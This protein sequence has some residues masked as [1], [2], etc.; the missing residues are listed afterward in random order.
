MVTRERLPTCFQYLVTLF[1]K[2]GSKCSEMFSIHIDPLRNSRI[3]RNKQLTNTWLGRASWLGWS[4]RP[5][6]PRNISWNLQ[7]NIHEYPL[8][9]PKNGSTSSQRCRL[10]LNIFEAPFFNIFLRSQTIIIHVGCPN[11]PRLQEQGQGRI[12]HPMRQL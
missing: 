11:V 2:T 5:K 7:V 3:L 1:T 9:V 6:G 4:T 10:N 12:V 8:N